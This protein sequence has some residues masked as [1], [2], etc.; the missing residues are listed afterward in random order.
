MASG[1]ERRRLTLTF[2]NGPTPRITDRVLDVLAVRGVVATFFVIGDRLG[3]T[4]GRDLARRAMAEGHRIGHHTATHSVL[5]GLAEHPE[6][7]VDTEIAAFAPAMEEFDGDQKLYR[8]YAGGGVLD[9]R[10]FSEQA[11]RYLQEHA[12]T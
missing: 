4:G 12:Y 8:P 10:V 11:V 1:P 5:L 2:D 9:R 3:Q 7:A 6:E